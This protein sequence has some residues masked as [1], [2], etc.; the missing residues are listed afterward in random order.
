MS[1]TSSS[2]IVWHSC[3]FSVSLV[4]LRKS[5]KTSLFAA[6]RLCADSGIVVNMLLHLYAVHAW[7]TMKP[8]KSDPETPRSKGTPNGHARTPD[9]TIHDAEEFEL[10]GLMT[11]EEEDPE[12][13]RAKAL[14]TEEGPSRRP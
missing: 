6:C 13:P 8:K 4:L 11:D 7:P 5:L 9:R 2:S 14:D 3:S 1:P 12:T 10:E